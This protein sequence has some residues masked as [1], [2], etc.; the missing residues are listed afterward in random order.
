MCN[1]VPAELTAH[2]IISA[3]R[4]ALLVLFVV[5]LGGCVSSAAAQKCFDYGP[6]VSLSGKLTSKVFPGPPNYESIRKGDQ[7]ETAIILVLTHPICT[8]TKDP[9]NYGDPESGQRSIQLVIT[10]DGDWPVIRRLI[11]KRATVTGTLFHWNTGH[12]HT[13][14]LI[15]VSQLR[16]AT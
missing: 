15:D 12:H 2:L 7:K 11:G 13:R 5:L 4:S 8:T 10:K 3:M 9:A 14:V 6:T 16:A 1:S